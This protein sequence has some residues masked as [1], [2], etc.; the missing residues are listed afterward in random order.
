VI[1]ILAALWAAVGVLLLIGLLRGGSLGPP[2]IRERRLASRETRIPAADELD[3]EWIYGD[4]PERKP[5]P[6]REDTEEEARRKAD[7]IVKDAELRALEILTSAEGARSHAEAELAREQARMAEK[8]KRLSQFL[9]DALEEVERAAAN[10]STPS[11]HDL[12]GVEALRDEL[13]STE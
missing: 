5:R 6:R 8:S 1:P 13:R 9:A 12:S 7:E 2:R 11:N 10:G 4:R 3:G